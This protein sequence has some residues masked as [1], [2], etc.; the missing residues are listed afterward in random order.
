MTKQ[1]EKQLLK[2]YELAV[3]RMCNHYEMG[4]PAIETTSAEAKVEQLKAVLTVFGIP[5]KE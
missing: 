1:E 4:S 3:D 2:M 5:Y